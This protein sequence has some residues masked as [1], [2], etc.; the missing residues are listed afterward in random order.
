MKCT[1]ARRNE[2]RGYGFYGKLSQNNEI[3]FCKCIG[4]AVFVFFFQFLRLAGMDF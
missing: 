1:S 4:K 2:V 3:E